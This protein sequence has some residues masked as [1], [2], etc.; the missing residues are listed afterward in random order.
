MKG[1]TLKQFLSD[2]RFRLVPVAE[3][4]L[5]LVLVAAIVVG[6]ITLYFA[7]DLTGAQRAARCYRPDKQNLA[8]CAEHIPDH[9]T[10]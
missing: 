3:N 8:T 9:R 6:V 10:N 4:W 2:E 5:A 7:Q 1:V